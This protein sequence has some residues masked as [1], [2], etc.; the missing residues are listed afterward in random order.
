MIEERLEWDFG[1][2]PFTTLQREQESEISIPAAPHLLIAC[3]SAALTRH[4]QLLLSEEGYTLQVATSI[5][6]ALAL[7]EQRT[8]QGVLTDLF[9]GPSD[10]LFDPLSSFRERGGAI[11]VGVIASEKFSV[12]A[13]EAYGFAFVLSL[14]LQA[15]RLFTELALGLRLRLTHAQERQARVIEAFFAALNAKN[16]QKTLRLCTRDVR[17]YP[18]ASH[19]WQSVFRAITSQSGGAGYAEFSRQP[20]LALRLEIEGMYSRPRGLAVQYNAWWALPNQRWEVQTD[21]LLFHF[22]DERIHQIGLPPP[23]KKSAVG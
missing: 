9:S 1:S 8:F 21:T 18:A 17:Y 16:M 3:S 22:F 13:A 20:P 7:L 10:G 6:E 19:P 2:W 12:E 15:E 5:E 4:L 11:P 23:D 14:P